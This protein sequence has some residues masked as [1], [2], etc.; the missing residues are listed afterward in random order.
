M[1][2]KNFIHSFAT[3]FDLYPVR[4]EIMR[5]DYLNPLKIVKEDNIYH[6]TDGN[7]HLSINNLLLCNMSWID[8]ECVYSDSKGEHFMFSTTEYRKAKSLLE[9]LEYSKLF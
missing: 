7:Y 5:V 1:K 2:F 4:R 3:I 9:S 6:I 8:S